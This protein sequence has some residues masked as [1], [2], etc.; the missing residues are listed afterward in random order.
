MTLMDP[1]L[2]LAFEARVEIAEP[3]LLSDVP[4]GERFFTPIIGGTVSGPKLNGSVLPY[5]GDWSAV[6][7]GTCELD[8]RYLLRADDGAIIDIH[9]KGFYRAD[10]DV[11]KRLRADEFVDEA[12][13]Y[14]RTFPVF[15]SDAPEHAWLQSAVFVG[16]ARGEV[17]DGAHFVC[18][19]FFTLD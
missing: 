4:G 1:K 8:A 2:T 10:P 15:R 19:R 16:L 13:Y 3:L 9:N 6:R 11:E 5:G 18:I 12:E 7:S 17:V 14:Y